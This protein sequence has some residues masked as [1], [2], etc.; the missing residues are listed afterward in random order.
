MALTKLTWEEVSHY[1]PVKNPDNLPMFKKGSTYY[2]VI[3]LGIASYRTVF[4][5]DEKAYQEYMSGNPEKDNI[6]FYAKYGVWPAPKE[7][8]DA[9]RKK[10]IT[11][12]PT[13]L[14]GNPESQKLFTP[15]ELQTLIPIGE[16]KWIEAKGKLPDNYHRPY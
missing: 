8:Q 10:R 9:A 14:I 6:Q 2:V 16:K 15:K 11:E 3:E 13:T 4:S 5:F 12:I 7:V 1:E